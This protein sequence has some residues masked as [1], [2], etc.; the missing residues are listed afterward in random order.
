MTDQEKT[1]F[2]QPIK[3]LP[4]LIPEEIKKGSLGICVAPLYGPLNDKKMLEWRLH[5]LN[6]G[7]K[8][9]H[10]YDRDGRGRTREWVKELK[11]L[12]KLDDTYTDAPCISPETCGTGLLEDRG[13]SGDQVGCLTL[14]LVR[15]PGPR[16]ISTDEFPMMIN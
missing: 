3:L 8:V 15:S 16:G 2:N 1:K 5:H 13:V 6:L 11:R 14:V 12:Y 4:T 7:V 9:V 10:W